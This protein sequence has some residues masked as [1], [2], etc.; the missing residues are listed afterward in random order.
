VEARTVEVY[1][2]DCREVQILAAKIKAMDR[3]GVDLDRLAAS[4]KR[5]AELQREAKARGL[6]HLET[7]ALVAEMEGRAFRLRLAVGLG[8]LSAEDLKRHTS[9]GA[10]KNRRRRA[11]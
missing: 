8:V 1:L 6:P 2:A 4:I 11:H 10:K 9:A 5:A 7:A 3:V